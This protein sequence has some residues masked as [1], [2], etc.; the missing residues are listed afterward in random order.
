MENFWS[1]PTIERQASNVMDSPKVC[2][3]KIIPA[4][5][6]IYVYIYHPSHT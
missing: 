3:R 1:P 2:M 6:H 5:W 4:C